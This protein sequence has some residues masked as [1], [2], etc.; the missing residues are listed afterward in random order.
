LF[1]NNVFYQVWNRNIT[2]WK[3]RRFFDGGWVLF[4]FWK[5]HPKKFRI[6]WSISFFY[7]LPLF[8][9]NQREI[10]FG[11]LKVWRK[12]I[13]VI[14]AEWIWRW[15]IALLIH[16]LRGLFFFH[17]NSMLITIY[18]FVSELSLI[19]WS[20]RVFVGCKKIWIIFRRHVY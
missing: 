9:G 4:F 3:K 11:L 6:L 18:W 12:G 8:V 17:P 19:F 16:F 15:C 2:R 13:Y 1:P 10:E 14:Y 7:W 5:N 20:K